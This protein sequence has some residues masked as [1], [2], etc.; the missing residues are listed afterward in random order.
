MAVLN[1]YN[2]IYKKKKNKDMD[3]AFHDY[4]MLLNEVDYQNM[5]YGETKSAHEV[6]TALNETETSSTLHASAHA[7]GVTKN[8]LG[9]SYSVGAE[10]GLFKT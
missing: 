7:Y 8:L 5:R 2:Y 10:A 3:N 6:S 9:P 4:P 1:F